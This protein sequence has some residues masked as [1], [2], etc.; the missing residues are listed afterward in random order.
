MTV[1]VP[2]PGGTAV[3]DGQP[4]DEIRKTSKARSLIVKIGKILRRAAGFAYDLL[5]APF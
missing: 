5:A 4:A 2:Q 1:V 3:D